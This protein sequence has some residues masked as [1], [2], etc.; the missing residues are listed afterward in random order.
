M[1][2]ENQIKLKSWI[3]KT[4]GNKKNKEVYTKDR[5]KVCRK[6]EQGKHERPAIK[7]LCYVEGSDWTDILMLMRQD[8]MGL[9]IF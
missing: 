9:C 8:T 1:K 4:S 6:N 7:L 2:G 3:A 5:T